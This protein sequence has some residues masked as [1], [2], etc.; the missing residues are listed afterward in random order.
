M[1]ILTW[2]V[3]SVGSRLERLVKVLQRHSPDIVCLQ[4]LKCTEENFPFDAVK[5][6][7]YSAAVYGQKT[8]NGVAIL[9]KIPLT[10]VEKGFGDVGAEDLSA[11]LISGTL[12]LP[13]GEIRIV[14]VY[15]PNGQEVGSEKFLY[16]LDWYTKLRLYLEKRHKSSERLIVLGDFNVAPEPR[17]VHDPKAWEGKILFS[18][19]ERDALANLCNFGLVD[20]FRLI[21]SE[22]GFYSW[23]DY[24]ALAFPFN[25]GVRIDF[26]LA[27]N[28]VAT[29]CISSSID[30]EERKGERPS[31]HAPV[32]ADFQSL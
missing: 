26:I 30:R 24:R 3:N 22:G 21:H 28:P 15:C 5:A 8:Y 10:K 32:L 20:T 19:P 7:G 1:K 16:K 12:M 6:A 2:N 31:D 23:W 25:K 18:Q 4:E 27:T 13:A 29:R 9:S 14:C 11:R 17:D